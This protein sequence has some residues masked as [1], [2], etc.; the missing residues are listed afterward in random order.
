MTCRGAEFHKELN[1]ISAKISW[2]LEIFV[3]LIKRPVWHPD[4]WAVKSYLPKVVDEI[5]KDLHQTV[6][7]HTR[8]VVQM[9]LL[10]KTF[11]NQL[12]KMVK[13]LKCKEFSETFKYKNIHL[14]KMEDDEWV[15]LQQYFK[16]NFTKYINN[17]G[18]VCTAADNII[19]LEAQCLSHF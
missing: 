7:E 9:H 13:E 2:V 19:F 1:S 10:A 17:N 6:K 3:R 4:S 11:A 16:G 5:I 8:K 14:A 18:K 15:T 12:S